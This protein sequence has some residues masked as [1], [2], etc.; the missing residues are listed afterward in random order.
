MQRNGAVRTWYRLVMK[1]LQI[2]W[3]GVVDEVRRI[4]SSERPFIFSE[5]ECHKMVSK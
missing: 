1:V 5:M 2:C 4:K 3:R